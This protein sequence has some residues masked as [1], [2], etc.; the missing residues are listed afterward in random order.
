MD[1]SAG[2]K[3]PEISARFPN[4]VPAI[5]DANMTEWM[6]YVYMQFPRPNVAGVE[7]TL[8]VVDANG[9]YRDIGTTTSNADGFFMLQ[10]DA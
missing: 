6:K 7:V 1:V 5:A 4:G 10:L 2:T 9:N 8:S 3:Q